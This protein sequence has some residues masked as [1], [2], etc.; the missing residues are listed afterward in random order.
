[1]NPDLSSAFE[2][3]LPW[4]RSQFPQIANLRDGEPRIYLDNAA[5]TLVPQTVADAMAEAALFANPQP[6][7]SWPG[8]PATKREHDRTRSHLADFLNAGTGDS[9]FLSESTTASL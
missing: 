4:I 5:G 7:R 9:L 6:E 8:A 3:L 2:R 1:M